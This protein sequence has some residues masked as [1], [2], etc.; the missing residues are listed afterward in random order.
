MMFY[1]VGSI[2]SLSANSTSSWIT[3][4]TK[5]EPGTS[6]MSTNEW[7]PSTV[8][9]ALASTAL[10]KKL[11]LIINW[12]L[13]Y[14]SY[15]IIIFIF[16]FLCKLPDTQGLKATSRCGLQLSLSRG[17][18]HL[19]L[20]LKQGYPFHSPYECRLG[21]HRT[22]SIGAYQSAQYLVLQGMWSYVHFWSI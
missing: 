21:Y 4:P 8:S 15:I 9:A 6:S 14:G 7:T 22:P 1:I 3:A 2:T 17:C 12:S 18:C 10:P 19:L 5:L 20:G 13:L 16:L 11:Q